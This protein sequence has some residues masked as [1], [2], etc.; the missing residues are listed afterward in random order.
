MYHRA[1]C[2]T[3]RAP[4]DVGAVLDVKMT[5]RNLGGDSTQTYVRAW[6]F[7]TLKSRKAP[8]SVPDAQ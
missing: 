1:L 7:D 3:R 4:T 2:G 5:L 8:V 6:Q